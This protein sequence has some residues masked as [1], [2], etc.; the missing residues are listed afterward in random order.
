MASKKRTKKPTKKVARASRP[1]KLSISEIDR[2]LA[3]ARAA[4]EKKRIDLGGVQQ[5]LARALEVAQSEVLA[6]GIPCVLRIAFPPR[7]HSSQWRSPWALVGRFVFRPTV[8]YDDLYRVFEAWSRSSSS[9]MRRIGRHRLARIRVAYV[10]AAIKRKDGQ[11]NEYTLSETLAY[12]AALQRARV[13]VTPDDELAFGG[14]G[15]L[16]VRYGSGRDDGNDAST[17]ESLFVWL[18]EAVGK[19]V[20]DG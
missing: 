9:S 5:R 8:I 14:L 15:S 4:A 19:N 10:D 3:V 16:A 6:I 18:S 17:I 13:A 11:R 7:S 1:P 20:M 12:A 2:R